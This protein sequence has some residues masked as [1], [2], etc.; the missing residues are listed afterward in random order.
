[1]YLKSLDVTD[2]STGSS[3][4][5]GD[6]SGSWQSIISEGGQIN[7]NSGGELPSVASTPPVTATVESIPVPWDGTH[8]ETSVSEVHTG[9]PWVPTSSPLPSM[10]SLPSGWTDSGTPPV[11]PPSAASVSEH[12]RVFLSIGIRN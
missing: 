6:K 10:T 2:Y 4:S 8:R 7:G 12:P 9:W 3:Y 5:Y 11:Q 1:M